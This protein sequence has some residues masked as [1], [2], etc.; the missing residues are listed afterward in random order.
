VN[1]Y[2]FV[3]G[4]PRSGTT[5]LQRMLDHHPELA[6]SNDPDF[7]ARAIGGGEEAVDPRD[8]RAPG[9]WQLLENVRGR[10]T[11]ARGDRRLELAEPRADGGESIHTA[12]DLELSE[13]VFAEEPP[14]PA[15]EEEPAAEEPEP[16]PDEEPAA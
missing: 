13:D 1:P 11:P 15:A 6:V 2:L 5:L 10:F 3:V 8:L 14:P 12:P 7:V 9:R 4:C 16:A